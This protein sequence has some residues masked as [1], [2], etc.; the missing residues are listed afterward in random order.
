MDAKRP[1]P[2]RRLVYCF[3]SEAVPFSGE[4]NAGLE[5]VPGLLER[6][7]Q[8]G[9]EV[10]EVDLSRRG[11]AERRALYEQAAMAA[12][13]GR[14]EIRRIFGSRRRGYG[15]D[16]GREVPALLVYRGED[17]FPAEVYPC[18]RRGRVMPIRDFLKGLPEAEIA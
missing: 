9:I 11:E 1:D 3:S 12:V 16:F 8:H 4:A 17:G 15:P 6:A 5:E 13:R 10:E 7:R 2:I 18:R 14:F